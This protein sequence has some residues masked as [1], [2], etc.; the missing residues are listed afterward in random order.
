ME[1]LRDQINE[2]KQLQK[3]GVTKLTG[4]RKIGVIGIAIVV[5]LNDSG[6]LKVD[7]TPVQWSKKRK[8]KKSEN[9][10]QRK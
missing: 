7:A 3:K 9:I 6:R 2:L 10:E 5:V 4:K 1:T 8:A